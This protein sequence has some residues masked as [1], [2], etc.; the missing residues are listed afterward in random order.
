MVQITQ[1][2]QMVQ[3][4]QIHKTRDII[5]TLIH[6]MGLQMKD[7]VVKMRDIV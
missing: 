6:V 7:G 5:V 2:V 1:M 4:A 3:M